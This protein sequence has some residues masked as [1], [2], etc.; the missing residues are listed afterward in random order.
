MCIDFPQYFSQFDHIFR[1][2]F[3]ENLDLSVFTNTS[4]VFEIEEHIG[5]YTVPYDVSSRKLLHIKIG[6]NENQ[7]E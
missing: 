7:Q 2:D 5:S 4:C 1:D 6:L 3:Q